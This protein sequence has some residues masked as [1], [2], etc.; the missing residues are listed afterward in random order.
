MSFTLR[1]I[2]GLDASGFE[3]ALLK[4]EQVA[5][6][7]GKRIR[8][9]IS[10]EGGMLNTEGLIETMGLGYALDKG[11]EMIKKAYEK[12]HQIHE[13]SEDIGSSTDNVQVYSAVFDG[14][15]KLTTAFKSL[16]E[17]RKHAMDGGA[18]SSKYLQDFQNLGVSMDDLRNKDM[19]G[20]FQQIGDNIKDATIDGQ[21]LADVSEVLGRSGVKMIDGFKRGIETMREEM[22]K[23]GQ[24]MTAGDIHTMEENKRAMDALERRAQGLIANA[25]GG[26]NDFFKHG[27]FD[28]Y[29]TQDDAYTIS[30]RARKNKEAND[31]A[32]QVAR[33]AAHKAA[34][35]EV[36]SIEEKTAEI[37]YR[38][39]SN[40]EK[41]TVLAEKRK[42]LEDQ[43]ASNFN[44]SLN[45]NDGSVLQANLKNQLEQVKLDQ[46]NLK[47]EKKTVEK[48]RRV[49]EDINA[50]QRV[51]AFVFQGEGVTL[52]RQSNNH[53]ANIEKHLAN[54]DKKG[55]QF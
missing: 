20:L 9:G 7:S 49:H 34:V 22:K 47:E 51:G 18:D 43:I 24:I 31:I 16:A 13:I 30:E 44:S 48:E 4:E 26:W 46:Q 21:K 54:L 36:A 37:H 50:A 28:E 17:A 33:D 55:G 1:A 10:G 11:V 53:L 5:R 27:S 23:S 6:A 42:S 40:D 39:L 15:E 19:D 25:V 35:S 12:A 2:L 3:S 45:T 14:A 52:Q 32:A 29:Q 41:R 38:S 8:E